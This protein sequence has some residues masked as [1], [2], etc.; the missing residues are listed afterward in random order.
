MT[1]F[2]RRWKYTIT[3]VSLLAAMPF[4]IGAAWMVT[5]AWIQANLIPTMRP[6]GY[7]TATGWALIPCALIA[8]VLVAE[9]ASI[10]RRARR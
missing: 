8:V 2:L 5:A 1:R 9:T 4:A 6:I 10:Y 7:W 3:G